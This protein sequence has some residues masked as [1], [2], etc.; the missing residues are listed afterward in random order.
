MAPQAQHTLEEEVIMKFCCFLQVESLHEWQWQLPV[1][2]YEE[3]LSVIEAYNDPDLQPVVV[4]KKLT[5]TQYVTIVK[6][7]FHS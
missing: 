5:E 7:K 6:L 2:R 4:M 3:N 1:A